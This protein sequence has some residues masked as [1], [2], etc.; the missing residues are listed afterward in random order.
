MVLAEPP[1]NVAKGT[2]EVSDA[3]AAH[4]ETATEAI[5]PVSARSPGALHELAAKHAQALSDLDVD[6]ADYCRSA[7]IHRSHHRLRTA[8]PAG[9]RLS[10]IES[11]QNFS[12]EQ[13][14][15]VE[16]TLEAPK[17]LFVYTGMGPQW[18][19]MGRQLFETEKVFRQA[20]EECDEAF[21]EFSGRSILD[22]LL[23]EESVSRM[24]RTEVAQPANAVLQIVRPGRGVRGASDPTP[25]WATASASSGGVRSNALSLRDTM[26]V[27]HDRSRLQAQLAVEAR[28]SPSD[29]CRRSSHADRVVRQQ[30]SVAAVNSANSITLAGDTAALE[31]IAAEPTAAGSST[32]SCK[33]RCPTT[34]P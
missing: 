3:A 5:L 1:E 23:A 4:V 28:C 19:A 29:G 25:Y 15:A 13:A 27:A 24:A 33:S 31:T 34:A 20:V 2:D 21:R 22:E 10:L 9:D 14:G 11:L 6:L 16:P 12:A 17:L 30:V 26:L 18:W 7:A 8:F 32:A